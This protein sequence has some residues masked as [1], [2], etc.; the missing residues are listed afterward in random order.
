MKTG[1]PRHLMGFNPDGTP[2]PN[3]PARK[4]EVSPAAQWLGIDG[5]TAPPVAVAVEAIPVWSEAAEVSAPDVEVVSSMEL[6]AAEPITAPTAV[7]TTAPVV[8]KATSA[9]V[10]GE[11]E[12]QEPSPADSWLSGIVLAPETLA[13]AEVPEVDATVELDP[14]SEVHI[15]H[16]YESVVDAPKSARTP[17]PRT[18]APKELTHD[19]TAAAADIEE[20]EGAGEDVAAS[21]V[22]VHEHVERIADRPERPARPDPGPEPEKPKEPMFVWR[23]KPIGGNR[24]AVNDVVTTDTRPTRVRREID[25]SNGGEVDAQNWFNDTL[26]HCLDLGVSDLH[27]GYEQDED[28]GTV[29]TA[30]IRVDGQMRLLEVVRGMDARTII[31]KFKAN[32][33]LASAGSFVPEESIYKLDVEG[34][35]RKARIALFRTANGGDAL[36]LRLPPTG[37]LRALEDLEFAPR[38]LE[39]FHELLGNS[40]RMIL[41]AGPM[42]SGKTTTAHAA[43][44]RVATPNRTVWSVED[45]VERDLPGLTQLEVDESNGAGFPALLPVLVRSDYDTLFLGEIRDKATAGAGVRQAKAGR[46]VITTIHANDNVTALLRLIELSED[47]PLSVMDAVLG[48]VSQRLVRKLN[49]DWDGADESKK[50][51]GRV[52]VHEVLRVTDE[53]TEAVMR[54]KPIAEIKRIASDSSESTFK[55]DAARLVDEGITDWEE[56]HRVLGQHS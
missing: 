50:Y 8:V 16:H 37:A 23:G 31:G 1:F 44:M 32:A 43:L 53:L 30:R 52:P 28:N 41:I 55:T 27:I 25:E 19:S 42:G 45:P 22:I 17:A 12:V 4:P 36:V 49:P 21:H 35:T 18:S 46:Q 56:I 26:Q 13:P 47:G 38:N 2:D 15:H 3:A 48:V 5:D 34:E 9:V 54:D 10:L 51:R 33:E 7:T 6:Q 40:N 24:N 29:L 11:P 14:K 39:L 20:V